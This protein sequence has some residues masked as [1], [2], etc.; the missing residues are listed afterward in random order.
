MAAGRSET[1]QRV[2]SM[3][4]WFGQRETAVTG[5][6]NGRW[7]C[8]NGRSGAWRR[9]GAHGGGGGAERWLEAAGDGEAPT[10]EGADDALVLR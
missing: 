10:E 1:H 6:M 3:A 2:W 8:Q 4:M 9:C 5:Q 7:R